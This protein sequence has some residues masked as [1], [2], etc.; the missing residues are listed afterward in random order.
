MWR[1]QSYS[2][3]ENDTTSFSLAFLAI[4]PKKHAL[5]SKGSRSH[6]EI[7][8]VILQGLISCGG[9]YNTKNQAMV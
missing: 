4:L 7:N 8:G 9:M 6:E 2:F 1:C 5:I 3:S